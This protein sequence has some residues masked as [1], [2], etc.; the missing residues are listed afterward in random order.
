MDEDKKRKKSRKKIIT[1]ILILVGII[2]AAWIGLNVYMRF[3]TPKKYMI[4]TENHIDFQPNLECSGFSSAYVLR[5]LGV[6]ADGM[7]L[8]QQIPNKNPDGTVTVDTLAAFLSQTYDVKVCNGTIWQFKNEI[9]KGVP[10]IAFVRISPDSTYYHYLPIVGYD[11]ENVYAAESLRNLYNAE[12]TY[13]NR[14]IP[15]KDFMNMWDTEV[16]TKN[17]YITIGLKK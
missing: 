17:T 16:V 6:N 5:S 4:K 1:C 2:V 13:Y 10:V 9:S 3:A 8:Y 15:L 12:E 11:E 14:K 7:E